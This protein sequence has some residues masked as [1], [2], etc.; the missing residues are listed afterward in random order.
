MKARPLLVCDEQFHT[1]AYDFERAE[2]FCS[3]CGLVLNEQALDLSI[4]FNAWP[5]RS[6]SHS[7]TRK[8]SRREPKFRAVEATLKEL[9]LDMNVQETVQKK[10]DEL[11]HI[12]LKKRLE[13]GY[14]ALT[15]ART[16][17]YA[18]HRMSQ[19]PMTLP[20]CA[21]TSVKDMQSVL[22]CYKKI[23][24]SLKLYVPKLEIKDYLYHL[25]QKLKVYKDSVAL[26]DKIL[27][28][29]KKSNYLKS[30]NPWGITAA[31]LY[32]SCKVTGHRITQKE[33]AQV[34]GVSEV[35]VRAN[36]KIL[37]LLLPEYLK[38]RV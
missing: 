36:S 23:C 12:V 2:I 20:E 22:R 38:R 4:E 29:S 10:L 14:S 33:L 37:S 6:N 1:I 17:L 28:E 7:R 24:E 13:R 27:S 34:A 32:I 16:L 21:V 9:I 8:T 3:K 35:T 5:K 19:R 18:A 30:S 26:A 31:A 15:L 11:C 25:A